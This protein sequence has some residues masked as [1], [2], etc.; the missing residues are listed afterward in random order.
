MDAVGRL[1]ELQSERAR[2]AGRVDTVER[3][4]RDAGV[5]VQ[6]ALAALA[7]AERDGASA[8]KRAALE[9]A[10][11]EAK[12]GVDREVWAAKVDGARH[13]VRDCDQAIRAHITANL[14]EL[15]VKKEAAGEA[16]AERINT[17]AAEVVA[18][19]HEWQALASSLGGLIGQVARPGP[20]DVSRSRADAAAQACQALLGQGGE[21]A[22]QLDRRNAPWDRL[23]GEAE[24][25]V[26]A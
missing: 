3:Q 17:A 1:T 4:M 8:P 21:Q 14:D 15:V 25:A 2:A 24:A 12:R 23:L 6:S 18:G 5:A 26:P 20:N 9:E 7:E 19:F 16:V 11:V 10:V 13:A 22:P